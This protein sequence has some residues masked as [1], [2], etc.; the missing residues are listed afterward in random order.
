MSDDEDRDQ[1]EQN[2]KDVH[3][4]R[5][6]GDLRFPSN[7]LKAMKK[8]LKS[9]IFHKVMELMNEEND[10]EGLST[11]NFGSFIMDLFEKNPAAVIAVIFL[12]RGNKN[13]AG[14]SEKNPVFF[15]AALEIDEK[16][17]T[18]TLPANNIMWNRGEN[19]EDILEL[20]P[21]N[22][23]RILP[24]NPEVFAIARIFEMFVEFADSNP[25][26]T[27]KE[28]KKLFLQPLKEFF[29]N[30]WSKG[31]HYS[32]GNFG[33][34]AL[35]TRVG[36]NPSIVFEIVFGLHEQKFLLLLARL[37]LTELLVLSKCDAQV[38]M[39][40]QN[41]ASAALQDFLMPSAPSR[42]RSRTD[43][44]IETEVDELE[45]EEKEQLDLGSMHDGEGLFPP[46]LDVMNLV[47]SSF[48]NVDPSKRQNAETKI[49]KE[50]VLQE[51][52]YVYFLKN[53]EDDGKVTLIERTIECSAKILWAIFNNDESFSSF[54]NK[55]ERWEVCYEPQ[56]PETDAKNAAKKNI[57]KIRQTIQFL[58]LQCAM[59]SKSLIAFAVLELPLVLSKSVELLISEKREAIMKVWLEKICKI[60]S[61]DDSDRYNFPH[62]LLYSL[63]WTFFD[64]SAKHLNFTNEMRMTS[65]TTTQPF[66][67]V[68]KR[69]KLLCLGV[70]MTDETDSNQS[71][72]AEVNKN[73]HRLS[74]RAVAVFKIRKEEDEVNGKEEIC[75][76]RC[77]VEFDEQE[78]LPE[79][80]YQQSVLYNWL[81]NVF[82]DEGTF[83]E[84]DLKTLKCEDGVLRSFADY[85]IDTAMDI[86]SVKLREL[87]LFQNENISII[88]RG[89][90]LNPHPSLVPVDVHD[91]VTE[92]I[93]GQKKFV[94]KD[95][96]KKSFK[97][98]CDKFLE[99]V[100][101]CQSVKRFL[102]RMKLSRTRAILYIACTA[103]VRLTKDKDVKLSKKY[104][105]KRIAPL[106]LINKRTFASN[107]RYFSNTT[108]SGPTFDVSEKGTVSDEKWALFKRLGII[109]EDS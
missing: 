77:G 66:P 19:P 28:E 38:A 84:T 5:E 24:L 37:G 57:V 87:L 83:S 55:N 109:P 74:S 13:Q 75:F 48:L 91:D 44:P 3:F 97:K 20:F 35:I 105:S 41:K 22:I 99:D 67:E 76:V 103:L 45:S 6:F 1:H 9:S 100:G 108:R 50:V 18:L 73:K 47:R 101:N 40:L 8:S 52:P 58:A 51:H 94:C 82:P 34:Y 88:A 31:K 43:H 70:E 27:S 69:N 104:M 12:K 54:V 17:N 96:S 42:K 7:N 72:I 107:P 29:F 68:I 59:K 49:V 14:Y 30:I 36:K 39:E 64:T 15:L 32:K 85:L 10:E 78:I 92:V 33:K 90:F 102:P 25:D 93:Y 26:W 16:N 95:L 56:V 86:E 81:T 98:N 61:V 65:L 62:D 2:V 11:D 63:L 106:V 60:V 23:Y 46:V 89:Q 21:F 4:T 79:L 71:F 53:M 80:Q